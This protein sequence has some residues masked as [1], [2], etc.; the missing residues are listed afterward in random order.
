M[1]IQV[2]HSL[3]ETSRVKIYQNFSDVRKLIKRFLYYIARYQRV[4]LQKV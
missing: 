4:Y 3:D 1:H 2:P